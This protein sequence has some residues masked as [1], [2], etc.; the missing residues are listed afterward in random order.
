MN[1]IHT[2]QKFSEMTLGSSETPFKNENGV[3]LPGMTGA[4]QRA[5]VKLLDKNDKNFDIFFN[6][7]GFHNHCVH[8]LLAAYSCGASP[9]LL[10]A[11]YK[12]FEEYLRPRL[13]SKVK[14]T[15]ENWTQYLSRDDLFTD[16]LEFFEEEIH[17]KGMEKTFEEYALHKDMFLR[18]FSG[19]FHPI[20][21]VGYG[22]EFQIS[23]ILAE[24][25]AC[26][27]VHK[28]RFAEL[29][30]DSYFNNKNGSKKIIDIV[31]DIIK[32]DQEFKS[33]LPYENDQKFLE[34]LKQKTDPVRKYSSQWKIEETEEGVKE[35]ARELYETLV[36]IYG[37]TAIRPD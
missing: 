22:I 33:F 15:K 23:L 31:N 5:V 12:R 21:H 36:I 34:V 28:N 18:L 20:I 8:H 16:Y 14:I 13:P 25:L 2:V 7:R 17:D 10:E 37:A 32:D 6:D 11:I 30:N 24:G 27:A 19:V 29:L 3:E 9:Q 35:A 26:T 1:H 4:S